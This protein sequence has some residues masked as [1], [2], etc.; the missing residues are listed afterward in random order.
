MLV[1]RRT[2]N[3]STLEVTIQEGK[4]REV[5]RVFARV[6]YK[7][8]ALTRTSIGPLSIRGLKEG[9][10][11]ALSREE[12]EALLSGSGRDRDIPESDAEEGHEDFGGARRRGAPRRSSF[13]GGRGG[14]A[15]RGNSSRGGGRGGSSARG[16]SRRGGA[17]GGSR[18]P[19]RSS[20]RR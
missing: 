10:W 11:R 8:L 15:R 19:R 16:S 5:R 14:N 4:N 6:G 17:R 12:V 13:S 1:Q 3:G 7:V 2:A 20:R 9:R 18:G